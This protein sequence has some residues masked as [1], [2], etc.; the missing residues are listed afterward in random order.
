MSLD[1]SRERYVRA[2]TRDT[3]SWLL[4]SWEARSFLLL[5]LRKLD[6]NGLLDLGDDG[7]EG[8]AVTV[9]MPVEVVEPAVSY[10]LKRKTL[11]LDGATLRMPNFVEAQECVA[12]DALRAQQYRERRRDSQPPLVTKRDDSSQ[13]V[14]TESRNVTERHAT[15][16]D[17]TDRHEASRTVT[18][19]CAVPSVPSVP[20]LP[21]GERAR[22]LEPADSATRVKTAPPPPP[23]SPAGLEVTPDA[24]EQCRMLG[25]P[26]PTTQDAQECALWHRAN[27]KPIADPGAALVRWMGTAKRHQA[28]AKS[29]DSPRGGRGP[30]KVQPAVPDAP[31]RKPPPPE[32][33]TDPGLQKL[34]EKF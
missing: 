12:S 9:M 13:D 2:F 15:S 3:P 1:W 26:I 31:W 33:E 6:R 34:L 28:S 17:V 4:A 10:W 19:C 30:T 23:S 11:V 25:Y 29:R 16:R 7:W 21:E 18:P 27:A 22:A 20:C 8:L 5:L 24:V 14:T 32:D